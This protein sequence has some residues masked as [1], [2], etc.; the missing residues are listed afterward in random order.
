MLGLIRYVVCF[1][2]DL[3]RRRVKI[4]GIAPIP[5][6]QWMLQ[7]AWDLI[8]GF[9]GYLLNKRFLPDDPDRGVTKDTVDL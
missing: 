4:A 5:D 1:V 3:P 6:G 8:D 9:G 2:I 7:V